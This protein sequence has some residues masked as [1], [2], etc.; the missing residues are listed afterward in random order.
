MKPKFKKRKRVRVKS[1]ISGVRDR[2][3]VVENVCKGFP[4]SQPLYDIRIDRGMG[5]GTLVCHFENEL[6]PFEDSGSGKEGS[7]KQ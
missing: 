4:W 2:T 6:E 1:G 5:K 3:G 7:A